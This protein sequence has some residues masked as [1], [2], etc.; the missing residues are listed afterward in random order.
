MRKLYTLFAITLLCLSNEVQS[1]CSSPASNY[2]LIVV[3]TTTF[4]PTASM[5]YTQGY[6]CNGGILTDS[7]TCCTRFVVVDSGGT[8]IVGPISYGAAY[9]LSGGT[10]NGQGASNNWMVYYE[11]GANVIN[12]TGNS[13]SCPQ[14]TYTASSCTMG[15]T[16]VESSKPVVALNGTLLN[17]R[18]SSCTTAQIELYDANGKL[19]RSENVSNSAICSMNVADLANGIY[20]YRVMQNGE[21]IFSDKVILA[22]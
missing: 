8:M 21:M 11:S 16:E 10:F 4:A 14:I 17:F 19:V 7:A 12:H 2:D 9:V 22:Q 13:V 20:M 6:V 15:L 18:F 1:Q 5:P 3:A